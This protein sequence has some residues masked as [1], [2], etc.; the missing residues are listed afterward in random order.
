MRHRLTWQTAAPLWSEAV[1]DTGDPTRFDQ[2][3]LLR[4]ASDTFM[5]DVTALLQT[6]PAKLKDYVAQRESW[7]QPLVGWLGQD[8]PR[9]HDPVKLYQP[10][11]GRFYLVGATLVCRVPGL[12]DHRVDAG[13]GEKASFVLRR[14]VPKNGSTFSPLNAGTYEEWAWV[15]KPEGGQWTP[16]AHPQKVNDDG[17][18]IEERVPLFPLNFVQDGRPRRLWLGLV[19]V[20]SRDAVRLA[21]Q[22]SPTAVSQADLSGDYFADPRF[23]EFDTQVADGLLGLRSAVAA[24]PSSITEIQAQNVL[25]FLLLDFAAFLQAHMP[26]VLAGT[27]PGGPLDR[28]HL[29]HELGNTD[30]FGTKNWKDAL[31]NAWTHRSAIRTGNLT[32][33]TLSTQGMSLIA[34]RTAVDAL[35][36]HLS[37]WEQIKQTEGS[38][39]LALA[40]PVRVKKALGPVPPTAKPEEA[41]STAS[42]K[43]AADAVPKLE[44]AGET[45]YTIRCVYDRPQCARLQPPLVSNKSSVPFQLAAFFDPEAP[46]RPL[47]ITMPVDTSIEGLR[48]FPKN[49]A[50]LVSDQLRRQMSRVQ[51]IKLGDLDSGKLGAE[52]GV[53]L[54]MICSFSIPIITICAL[55]LLLIIVFVL[56]IVFWW[57]P[58]FRIC[59]PLQLKAK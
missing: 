17:I 5:E 39:A 43:A 21:R 19:P 55:L 34:I 25:S 58:F 10:T 26:E 33:V 15:V 2:P 53:N 54:G 50:F 23:V 46:A 18:A 20:S 24:A 11:H 48:R 32:G 14:L 7:E 30:F 8:N 13:Q 47:R 56:N 57:L 16:T 9:R 22:I 35:W 12:P 40:L 59:L 28:Q 31:L 52:S 51:G 45:Y 4:F 36:P 44:P 29:F 3:A 6:D 27:W 38:V 42:S 37:Q 1:R 41:P 49:V